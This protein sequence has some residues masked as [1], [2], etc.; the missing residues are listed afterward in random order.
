MTKGSLCKVELAKMLGLE[1]HCGHGDV[2][3]WEI[4]DLI[5]N[6]YM[7]IGAQFNSGTFL[8]SITQGDLGK[9]KLDI[10]LSDLEAEEDIKVCIKQCED[11]LWERAADQYLE[12]IKNLV[13]TIK[14]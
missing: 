3:K 2:S 9:D 5:I 4:V 12:K 13:E 8:V 6:D 14:V 11:L 1:A 10:K 7:T